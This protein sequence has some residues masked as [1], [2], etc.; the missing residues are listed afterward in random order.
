M[1]L[2]DG[3]PLA[4]HHSS[5]AVSDLGQAIGFFRGAFGFVVDFVEYGMSRRIASIAGTAGL[6]CDVA[7]LRCGA[8]AHVLE[9]IAFHAEP[10]APGDERPFRP[11]SA[12]VAFVVADLAT[13]LARA[14]SLG[15]VPL[16]RVTEFPESAAVY[17]RAP[18]GAF[19]E[20]EQLRAPQP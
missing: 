17:C 2:P 12:H 8:S 7:Q 5:L 18:G 20:I 6:T 11:G 3:R 16:G 4:W 19:I 15:A 1:T 14:E 13:A 9:L 10:A